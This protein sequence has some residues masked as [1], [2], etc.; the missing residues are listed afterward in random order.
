MAT[1]KLKKNTLIYKLRN[2][3]FETITVIII[4]NNIETSTTTRNA[5]LRRLKSNKINLKCNRS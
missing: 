2:N 4:I 5:Q 1:E 3:K